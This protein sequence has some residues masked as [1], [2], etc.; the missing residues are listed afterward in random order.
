MVFFSKNHKQN[1]HLLAI[2]SA[3]SVIAPSASAE[4]DVIEGHPWLFRVDAFNSLYFLDVVQLTSEIL[5]GLTH[6]DRLFLR[7]IFL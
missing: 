3:G 5:D 7:F 2:Y 4:C 1:P 6:R